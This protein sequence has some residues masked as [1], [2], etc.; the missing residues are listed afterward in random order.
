MTI[1]DPDK[2]IRATAP[3]KPS[4][5]HHSAG[6][7]GFDAIFKHVA[8]AKTAEPAGTERATC[9]PE[10]QRIRFSANPPA[11]PAS[12]VNGVEALVDSL[13]DFQTR[14]GANGV[15]L[16]SMQGLVDRMVLES[17]A[18]T[19]VAQGTAVDAP[20]KRIV[21]RALTLTSLEVARFYGGHYTD[22]R[23]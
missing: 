1:I 13:A 6:E 11:P 21:D 12:L 17:R 2:P 3:M 20:L 5:G 4:A 9:A 16:K 22:E 23:T 14:L 8:A 7:G 18:L 15:S 19:R 10:V